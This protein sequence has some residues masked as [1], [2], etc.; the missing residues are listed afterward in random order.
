MAASPS[1]GEIFFYKLADVKFE[2]GEDEGL[3]GGQ[4]VDDMHDDECIK[5]LFEIV[6]TKKPATEDIS[7]LMAHLAEQCSEASN[8]S[9]HFS[10]LDTPGLRVRFKNREFFM[11]WR[12]LYG[13]LSNR[14]ITQET[15][16]W[17]FSTSIVNCKLQT[18]H[19]LAKVCI[20]SIEVLLEQD[21]EY[22]TR[23]F[24]F[25]LYLPSGVRLEDRTALS[26]M[27]IVGVEHWT[28]ARRRLEQ[29]IRAHLGEDQHDVSH[30]MVKLGDYEDALVLTWRSMERRGSLARWTS[31]RVT[32]P[33]RPPSAICD[34]A[35]DP[36]SSPEMDDDLLYIDR[37]QFLTTDE[38]DRLLRFEN[39]SCV[40]QT[41]WRQDVRLWAG[42]KQVL[43]WEIPLF[44]HIPQPEDVRPN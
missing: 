18:S 5:N 23:Y 16:R 43:P 20:P 30:V 32:S 15:Y 24:N 14:R 7:F 28:P 34:M 29:R 13:R 37:V 22:Q 19:K 42:E 12:I 2:L 41:Y 21:V 1:T 40:S 17:R 6:A 27:G 39:H 25:G 10:P 9:G 31:D 44:S 35:F 38:R 33:V 36:A 26:D 3:S 11:T 8:G 4:A